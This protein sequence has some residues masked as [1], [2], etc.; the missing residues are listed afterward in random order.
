ME[1]Q[2]L[3]N[4]ES[5]EVTVFRVETHQFV[6]RNQKTFHAVDDAFIIN[7]AKKVRSA[8]LFRKSALKTNLGVVIIAIAAEKAQSALQAAR[9]PRLDSHIPAIVRTQT[10]L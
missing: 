7:N 8:V 4:A 9:K 6:M 3:I 2:K 1:M 5:A 10:F